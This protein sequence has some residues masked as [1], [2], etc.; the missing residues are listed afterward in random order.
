MV[1]ING[2]IDPK[3]KVRFIY[4]NEKVNLLVTFYFNS[5]KVVFLLNVVKV[6]INR[7][8]KNG[9]VSNVEDRYKIVIVVDELGKNVV[10]LILEE[11]NI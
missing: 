4:L 3:M 10:G 6:V 9:M 8:S 5:K 1:I 7:I 2:K 11:E